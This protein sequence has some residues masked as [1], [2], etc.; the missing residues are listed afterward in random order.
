MSTDNNNIEGQEVNEEPKKDASK[1]DI[2]HKQIF[3]IPGVIYYIRDFYLRLLF[4]KMV[5]LKQV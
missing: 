5:R 2:D 4:L 3:K 1:K